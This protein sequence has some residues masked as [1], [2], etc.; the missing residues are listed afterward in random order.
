MH[1]WNIEH[2][3]KYSQETLQREQGKHCKGNK[4]NIAKGTRHTDEQTQKIKSIVLHKHSENATGEKVKGSPKG[5]L[6]TSDQAYVTVSAF[7]KQTHPR[8]AKKPTNQHQPPLPNPTAKKPL[9]KQPPKLVEW[10]NGQGAW[11][12]GNAPIYQRGYLMWGAL[13]L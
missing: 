1:N 4:T 9:Q 12:E 7:W 2:Y 11:G 13:L 3:H 6:T 8:E 10:K 5:L